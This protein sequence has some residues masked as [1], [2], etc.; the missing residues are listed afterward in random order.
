MTKVATLLS[1]I[2]VILTA[3]SKPAV[4]PPNIPEPGNN[5]QIRYTN[6]ADRTIAFGRSPIVLDLNGDNQYDLFFS[7]QLVGDPIYQED[8]KQFLA[9]SHI[10]TYI[11]VNFTEQFPVLAL[12]QH[13]PLQDFNGYTWYN[14]ASSVLMERIE[15][16]NGNISWRGNW[17]TANK[18]YLPV[19]VHK[20]GQ[21]FNGWIELTVD[22]NNQQ[23]TLHKMAIH[24][25]PE[26]PI[27][28]GY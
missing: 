16:I 22:V 15:N 4:E 25:I 9:T 23:I 11:L 10:D 24:T 7:T 19:Q 2:I 6:L 13:I 12:G 3:C 5:A 14:A 28:A 27:R 18:R 26:T 17:L 1:T 8:K 20:N 21:R